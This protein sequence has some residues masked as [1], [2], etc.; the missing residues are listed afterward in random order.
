M[1]ICFT[2]DHNYVDHCAVVLMSVAKNNPHAEVHFHIVSQD[3]N[4]DDEQILGSLAGKEGCQISFYHVP[5]ALLEAYQLQWGHKRLSMSVYY[6]CVLASVLPT[7]V[8]KVIYMDCDV[9]VV[10]SLQGL[11]ECNLNGLAVAGVQD[12]MHTRDEYFERLQYDKVYGYFNGG[13][14]VLNMD[15]WRKNDVENRCKQYFREHRERVVRNDQDIMNAVLFKEKLMVDM[16]WNVQADFYLAKHYL[17]PDDRKTCVSII[18]H[19]AIIHFSYH[20]KPWLYHCDHPMRSRFFYYQQFTPYNDLPRL[21]SLSSRCHRMIHNLPYILHL[22]KRKYI[23]E[24]EMLRYI[25]G[26]DI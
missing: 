10:D 22:K 14:V 17:H 20:K 8:N 21:H 3:L 9:V 12:L 7:T 1:N 26:M 18:A 2:I 15:Y 11:W 25:A 5:D 4:H 23:N 16:R 13:V 6:R 24:K 19:P